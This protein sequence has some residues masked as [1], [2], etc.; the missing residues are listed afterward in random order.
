M[1]RKAIITEYF[2][3]MHSM[4]RLM[5]CLGESH[6][7]K[8]SSSSKQV[9]TRAQIGVMM[10]ITHR[11]MHTV[12]AIA[13]HLGVSPSAATQIVNGL[14]DANLVDREPNSGDRRQV[15]ITITIKG[16]KFL[17]ATKKTMQ[18]RFTEILEPLTAT[19]LL[20]LTRIQKK[21]LDHFNK[22]AA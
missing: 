6:D 13:D 21:I 12:K 15:D 5:M 14:V 2:D 10:L 20:E 11:N 8:V 7:T 18:Q 1:N 22:A 3:T 17:Q 9:L 4:R 16:K 19:E